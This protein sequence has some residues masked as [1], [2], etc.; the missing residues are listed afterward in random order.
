MKNKYYILFDPK[1]DITAFEL[2]KIL[3]LKEKMGR[4]P[5]DEDCQKLYDDLEQL[6]KR[7]LK[8][9]IL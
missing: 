2:A 3:Q 5:F 9:E 7:H 8:V 4:L 6:V 1:D